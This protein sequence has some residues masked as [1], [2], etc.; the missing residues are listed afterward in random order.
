MLKL[1]WFLSRARTLCHQKFDFLAKKFDRVSPEFMESTYCIEPFPTVYIITLMSKYVHKIKK[2]PRFSFL[3]VFM[4][5]ILLT[6]SKAVNNFTCIATKYKH[7][8]SRNTI[9]RGKAF[10]CLRQNL[11]Y[12]VATISLAS[13]V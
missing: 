6:N 10:T 8:Q 7:K 4:F 2:K 3:K 5:N 12:R 1:T 9:L 13:P 11:S